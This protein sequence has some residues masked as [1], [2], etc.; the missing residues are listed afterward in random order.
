[1]VLQSGIKRIENKVFTFFSLKQINLPKS[2][3]YIADDAFDRCDQLSCVVEPNG[4]SAAKDTV[5][6]HWVSETNTIR[7]WNHLKHY[8]WRDIDRYFCDEI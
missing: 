6:K 2:L 4:L 8:R 3:T 7:Q 5:L 1:M